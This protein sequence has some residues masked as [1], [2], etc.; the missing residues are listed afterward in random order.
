MAGREVPID[1]GRLDRIVAAHAG[2]RRPSSSANPKHTKGGKPEVKALEA[3]LG[4][5]ITERRGV[6]GSPRG[7]TGTQANGEAARKA[8]ADAEADS[9]S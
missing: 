2:R 5:D 6:G 8:A 1:E 3:V 9:G 7:A 4:Y